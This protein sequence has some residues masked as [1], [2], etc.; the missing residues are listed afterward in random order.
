MLR[1]GMSRDSE[2][3]SVRLEKEV[4]LLCR[5]WNKVSTPTRQRYRIRILDVRGR[6]L[7]Y[8]ELISR[9]NSEAE[10]AVRESLEWMDELAGSEGK[11]SGGINMQEGE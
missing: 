4:L 7:S 10:K 2:E 11:I 3:I 5:I 6:A 1:R 8:L 9:M